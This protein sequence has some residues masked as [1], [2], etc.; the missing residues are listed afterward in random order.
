M[1][2]DPNGSFG[3]SAL[4]G[5]TLGAAILGGVTQIALNAIDG[6]TGKDLFKGVLGAA[7]G[8]GFNALALCLT[9]KMGTASFALSAGIGAVIQTSVDTIEAAFCN[10]T[11]SII[12]I[13]DSLLKNYLITLAGNW[14]GAKLITTNPGWFQTKRFLS[15]FTRPYGQRI[16]GQTAV[17][18]GVSMIS[19]II[20]KGLE[21]IIPEDKWKGFRPQFLERFFAND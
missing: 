18:C 20:E 16:L 6:K 14:I 11:I 5:I 3:I 7:L 10:E 13:T 19:K 21:Y 1:Y 15:V 4:I 12:S 8:T 9:M 2:S 17:G